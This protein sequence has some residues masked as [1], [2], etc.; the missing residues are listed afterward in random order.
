MPLEGTWGVASSGPDAS[1]ALQVPLAEAFSFITHPGI[2]GVTSTT[3]DADF[4]ITAGPNG[5]FDVLFAG[6]GVKVGDREGPYYFFE[7]SPIGSDNPEDDLF[8]L[9]DSTRFNFDQQPVIVKTGEYHH[10]TV[11]VIGSALTLSVDGVVY[12]AATDTQLLPPYDMLV[13]FY[14]AGSVDKH[15]RQLHPLT[16]SARE[17]HALPPSARVGCRHARGDRCPCSGSRGRATRARRA[18][19]HSTGRRCR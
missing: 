5:D 12:L 19:R 14:N 2:M 18:A 6:E 13:G 1:N 15:C 10:V 9:R 3:V 16:T 17:R 4:V 7:L 8:L 11:S